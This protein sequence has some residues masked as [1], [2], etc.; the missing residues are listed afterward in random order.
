MATP[1]AGHSVN[2]ECS[3]KGIESLENFFIICMYISCDTACRG[4]LISDQAKPPTI[5][6]FDDSNFAAVKVIG[7]LIEAQRYF[8]GLPGQDGQWT[9]LAIPL[10]HVKLPL[11]SH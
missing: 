9:A 3:E 4:A 5:P 10:R 2:L 8:V 11:Y 6:R 7:H 1:S